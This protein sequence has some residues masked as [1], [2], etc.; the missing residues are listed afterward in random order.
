[1]LFSHSCFLS[2]VS[3]GSLNCRGLNLCLLMMVCAAARAGSVT[4]I[5]WEGEEDG[6]IHGSD[7]PNRPAHHLSGPTQLRLGCAGR[8]QEDSNVCCHFFRW[9]QECEGTPHCLL[10]RGISVPGGCSSSQRV[11]QL[12]CYQ[13]RPQGCC[14]YGCWRWYSPEPQGFMDPWKSFWFWI[15]L[16]TWMWKFPRFTFRI[17]L[18]HP[19]SL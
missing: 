13:Q 12:F 10:C 16:E 6:C 19:A 11:W 18:K 2:F 9:T 5:E 3:F 1:M 17:M 15:L 8:F 14:M 7:E 4:R